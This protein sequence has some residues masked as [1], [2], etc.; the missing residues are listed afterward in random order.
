[1][2]SIIENLSSEKPKKKLDATVSSLILLLV[3]LTPLLF[4]NFLNIPLII[5]KGSALFIAILVAFVLW[6]VARLQDGKFVVPKSSILMAGTVL[7]IVFLISAVFSEAPKISLL[8]FGYEVGTSMAL[9]LFFVLMFLTATLF[10][11]HKKIFQ[12]YLFLL[13]AGILVFIYTIIQQTAVFGDTFNFLPRTIVGTYNDTAVFFGLTTIIAL[14]SLELIALS[15]RMRIIMMVSLFSSLFGLLM[16]NFSFVW[17]ILGIFSLVLF[18]YVI[19]FFS[20]RTNLIKKERKVPV[21][22]L[23]VMLLALLLILPGQTIGDF[24]AEK[25]GIADTEIRPS[26]MG[27]SE[28]I[29]ATI[30]E[31]PIFGVGPNRFT[32]AWL[33]HKPQGINNTIAWN[34]DF[35]FGVGIIPS[36]IVTTGLLGFLAWLLFLGIF[37]VRG[38]Q[39]VV[40][41]QVKTDKVSRYMM[42]S[43]F[44]SALYLWIVSIFYV[45][46]IVCFS[47]AF[48]FTGIFVASLAQSGMIKRYSVSFINDPR[49]NFISVLGLILF[50]IISVLTGYLLFQQLASVGYFYQ[51]DK[52]INTYGNLE[53]AEEKLKK[54][55]N[56]APNDTYYRNLSS[57][58]L[59]ELS[60]VLN[61]D[62]GVS[63]D[64]LRVQFNTIAPKIVEN[65]LLATE[66]N[67]TNYLNWTALAQSYT[68]LI[69]FLGEEGY[70]EAKNAYKIAVLYNPQN[71]AIRLLQARLELINSNNDEAKQYIQEAIRMKGNYT[72]AIFLLSQIQA[73]E[74]DLEQAIQSTEV[75]SVLAPNDIGVFFQLGFLRYKN[76]DWEGAVSAFERAVVLNEFYSNARYFL[77]LSYE[78][79]GKTTEAIKQFEFVEQ[80]NPDNE[81][82]KSILSNLRRGREPFAI[83]PPAK[84]VL[85]PE[86]RTELPV[87]EE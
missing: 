85:P 86:E 18:V 4:L 40:M 46:N 78:K 20:N 48:L 12:L 19:S 11:A 43:S 81:E 29:K 53:L 22:S 1:M 17:Q 27:T 37:V 44:I 70:K 10:Q 84:P 9:F 80:L 8:G 67:R 77:G 47:F 50:I 69:P 82:V 38:A 13:A 3:F 39:F 2:S 42:F 83:D 21:F 76:E 71:P 26:W 79:V 63:E 59:T 55:I 62:T 60:Y 14:S 52:A 54:A 36:F 24:T 5:G 61:N 33:A 49:L 68:S 73:G 28:V 25:F 66:I 35:P 65:A 58:H 64:T 57:L 31:S 51:Y 15:K 6:L 56:L 23:I 72:E 34:T 74:G 16:I 75:T 41:S 87:E 30:K 32:N 45:P 7:P